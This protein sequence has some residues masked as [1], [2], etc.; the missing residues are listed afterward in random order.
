WRF[1]GI[2]G[3]PEAHNK[4]QTWNLLM[5]LSPSNDFPWLCGRDF[6]KC[7]SQR[8]KSN[9]INYNWHGQGFTWS[10][11]RRGKHLIKARL[12]RFVASPLWVQLFSYVV[13]THIPITTSGHC[14]IMIKM[15]SPEPH[16]QP[17][18]IIH[19]FEAM[20]IKEK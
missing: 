9:V 2:Y 6:K 11:K 4:Y 5:E 3:Q 13:V 12:D 19:R 7:L 20:W 1:S 8:K 10:N 18:K 16:R 14:A 17:R 15:E